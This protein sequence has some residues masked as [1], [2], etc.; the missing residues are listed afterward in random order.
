MICVAVLNFQI[1]DWQLSQDTRKLISQYIPL[2]DIMLSRKET[3][4][5]LP[6]SI[7][8]ANWKVVF[9]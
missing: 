9:T 6:L 4:M 8:C 1:K 3:K 7:T 2:D 5:L